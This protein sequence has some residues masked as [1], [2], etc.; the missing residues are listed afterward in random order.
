MLYLPCNHWRQADSFPN[1]SSAQTGGHCW[2]HRLS[3]PVLQHEVQQHAGQALHGFHL[4][5]VPS[6]MHHIALSNPFQMYVCPIFEIFDAVNGIA[7]GLN[8][9]SYLFRQ[10]YDW[11][12]YENLKI[13]Q[14]DILF[15]MNVKKRWGWNKTH[16]WKCDTSPELVMCD[17]MFI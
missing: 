4:P 7:S 15:E 1:R 3:F 12:L 16:E 17:Y 5:A 13:V 2:V 9:A 11:V 14:L 6:C 8:L 10:K